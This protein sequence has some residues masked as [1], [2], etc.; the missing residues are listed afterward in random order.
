M[1]DRSRRTKIWLALAGAI[2]LA[3]VATGVLV[4]RDDI[5]RTGLDPK[6]PFQTYDPPPAP[7][8]SDRAAWRLLPTDPLTWSDEAPPADVFF[9]GPTLY[10]GGR[11]WNAPIDDARA[12]R[13]F[14]RTVGPNY[15]GPFVEA[16]RVFAPRYRQG[17]LYTM[18][19]LRDDAREARRFAYEDVR[20]AF[21][22][23][24]AAYNSGRPLI[25]VGVEQGGV[26]ASRLLA[27]EIA[28][29]PELARRL[30]AAYLVETA[31]E[32]QSPPFTPCVAAAEPGCLAAWVSAYEGERDR[33]QNL[34]DRSLVWNGQ[35]ELTNL[36]GPPLCFNPLL[37]RVSQE[38]APARLAKGA[39]NAT[40]L[41]WGARPALQTRQ[42]SAKCER[43][44]LMVSRPR[45]AAFKR[46]GSW[47][48]RRKVPGYNLFYGDLEA[49]AEARLAT[50]LAD[51]NFP[52]AARP[53]VE[54]AE[55][56]RAPVHRID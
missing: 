37:G 47:A 28:G 14:R 40:G 1:L 7:D 8:Y 22:H 31:V 29:D 35:G 10:D 17:S 46:A 42:V 15:V 13:F 44:V 18:L 50:L 49:D 56:P 53:I 38:A 4:W 55:V 9:V 43:G 41:E 3:I 2:V 32:A 23:Y 21:R 34:R 19:T 52:R 30:V 11:H 27:E 5:L 12:D 25:L 20:R 54:T 51:P 48:D 26:L 16:G 45:S 6:V 33:A 36:S 24:L 39:T